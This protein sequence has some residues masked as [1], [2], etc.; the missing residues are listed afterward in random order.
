MKKHPQT[1]PSDDSILTTPEVC[2]KYKVNQQWIYR[3]HDL[4]KIYVGGQL[5]FS[6]RA[7]A[8]FFAKK[9]VI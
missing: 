1:P 5:R 8:A 9:G 4:P 3:R 7:L 6:A 2:A